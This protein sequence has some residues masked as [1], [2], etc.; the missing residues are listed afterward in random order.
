MLLSSLGEARLAHRLSEV[1]LADCDPFDLQDDILRRINWL[2][3]HIIGVMVFKVS[4][5]RLRG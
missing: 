4:L 2:V 1:G 5:A 3:E